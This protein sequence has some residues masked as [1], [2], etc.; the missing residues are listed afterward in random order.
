MLRE[1]GASVEMLSKTGCPDLLVGFR[2][3]VDGIERNWLMEIKTDK[4]KLTADEIKW[5][6]HWRG[7]VAVVR[8][9]DEALRLIGAIE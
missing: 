5:H 6:E 4:G 7:Q 2:S 1:V 8:D 3:R 9:S